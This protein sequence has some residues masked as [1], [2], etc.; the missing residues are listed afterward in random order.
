MT[1]AEPSQSEHELRAELDELQSRMR[2]LCQEL[3]QYPSEPRRGRDRAGFDRL[4]EVQPAFDQRIGRGMD[5]S[6]SGIA[7]EIAEDLTFKLKV[8]LGTHTVEGLAR[9]VNL[10]PV[11]DGMRRLGFVFVE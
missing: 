9:L 6:S 2:D 11:E 3:A 1:M 4:V 7:L 10:T 5:I 8:D